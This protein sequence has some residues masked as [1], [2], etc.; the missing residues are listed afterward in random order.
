MTAT[1]APGLRVRAHRPARLR[2]LLLLAGA[3]L[4]TAFFIV[5]IIWLLAG[6]FRPTQETFATSSPLTWRTFVPH[7]WTLNNF[8]RALDAGFARNVGNSIV[9]AALTVALGLVCCALAAFA[10]AV[11]DFPGRELVFGVVVVS[12]LVPFEAVAIPLAQ[13]FRGWG[14]GNTV[15]GLVLPGLGNGLAVFTLRQNFLGIPRELREAAT[16]DGAGWW[17]IFLRVYLPLSRPALIGAGLILFLFQWQ[18]YL[19]PVLVTSDPV[20][21]LAP[22]SIARTFGAFAND[23]G[24]VFAETVIIAVIPALILLALQRY[25]VASIASTGTKE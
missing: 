22:V 5:P 15:T 19:W 13:S 14:L 2:T 12:F 11:I 25:F 21:D 17:R 8:Q 23:Y 16:V 18:A 20:R 24:K 9:V 4:V 7:E 6:A 1:S 3:V 10:L